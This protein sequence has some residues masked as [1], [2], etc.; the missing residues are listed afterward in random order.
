M[1]SDNLSALA[2]GVGVVALITG[3]GI[4]FNSPDLNKASGQ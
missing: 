3:F 1:N 4:Y 2:V